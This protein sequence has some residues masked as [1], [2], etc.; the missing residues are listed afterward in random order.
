MMGVWYHISILHIYLWLRKLPLP[1]AWSSCIFLNPLHHSSAVWIILP[2]H[3]LLATVHLLLI[4][5]TTNIYWT[6]VCLNLYSVPGFVL[7]IAEPDS[8]R[9][10]IISWKRLLTNKKIIYAVHRVLFFFL[11]NHKMLTQCCSCEILTWDLCVL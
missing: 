11:I 1:R 7:S 10:L 5:L 4:H 9:G 6:P 8:F 2:E 3:S